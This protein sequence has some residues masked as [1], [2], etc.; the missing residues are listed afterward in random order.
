MARAVPEV[1]SVETEPASRTGQAIFFILLLIFLKISY[2]SPNNENY[3]SKRGEKNTRTVIYI[4]VWFDYK[5]LCDL[6]NVIQRTVNLKSCGGKYSV[7]FTFTFTFTLT[8]QKNIHQ[9][10]K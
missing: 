1:R 3:C 6:I 2:S 10:G 7:F 8:L 9:P 4:F 5:I